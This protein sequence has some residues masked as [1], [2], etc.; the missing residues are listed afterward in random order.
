MGDPLMLSFNI[1]N[2]YKLYKYITLDQ[3]LASILIVNKLN[4][5]N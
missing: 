3:N 2:I 5:I 4:H 1:K